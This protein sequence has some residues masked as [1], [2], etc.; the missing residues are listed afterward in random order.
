MGRLAAPGA[1]SG[2]RAFA[3][4]APPYERPGSGAATRLL[5]LLG[6]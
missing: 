3:T 2:G 4:M 1:Q 5:N 6:T